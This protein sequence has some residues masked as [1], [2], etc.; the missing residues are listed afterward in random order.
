T[1]WVSTNGPDQPSYAL[2][3]A[4]VGGKIRV[5][6]SYT[7]GQGFEESVT[8][9]AIDN[10]EAVNDGRS[11]SVT[12][13]GTRSEKGTLNADTSGLTDPDGLGTFRYDWQRFDGTS[14]VS[15][16]GPD[17][18]SYAL[19]A[20]D[21]G[22]KIRVV[23]SYTDGQGFEESVT[24]GAI[25]NI[26]AVNDGRSGSVTIFGTTSE[27]GTLQADTSGLTDPDG[28]GTFRYDWQRFDGTSW[29]STNAPDKASYA[30]GA[31]DVGGKIR[32]VVSYTDGQGFEESVTSGS[33]DNIE[34][35]NDGRSGE[36]SIEGFLT[37]D[38]VLT[39][40]T[41][42]LIDPDGLGTLH[43]DWQRFDGTDWI[44][45]DGA[46]Q[47]TYTLGDADVGARI[48]VIVS[49][50]DGQG[51][52]ES[53]T[54][55]GSNT[56][57]AVND[58][59]LGGV[60][61]DGS[62][63][64]DEVLTANTGTLTDADGLGTL[65]Y[66]WQRLDGTDW[67]S[68][69][70]ANQSTYRLG[71]ADADTRIRVIVSYTDGQGFEESIT[72]AGTAIIGS[73]NDPY[74]GDVSIEGSLV[75][76][77]VLT[78]K[79][80]TLTDPDGLGTLSYV[81][82]RFDGD[83]WVSI[84]GAN[85][86][87]YRLGD[88]DVG[89]RIRVIVSYTD[90]QGY[91]ERITSDGSDTIGAF[92][93]GRSGEVSIEGSLTEDQVLTAKTD[94]LADPD[95][96]GT[97]RYDWQRFDG[98]DW[99][100]IDGANQSTYRLG[101]ADVGAK[102]R[103]TV[104]YTDG[105]GFAESSTSAGSGIIGGVNDAPVLTGTLSSRVTEGAS[106]VLTL[107]E[108]GY[109]DPDNGADDVTFTVSGLVNGTVMVNG[110]AATSFTG[111]ELAAGQV[112]FLHDGSETAVAGFNVSV[113]D[114]DED[115]SAPASGVFNFKVDAE[116]D[117]PELVAPLEN[118]R[119]AQGGAF[120]FTLPDGAFADDDAGD[121]LTYSAR[122][123]NGAALPGWLVFDPATNTF[124]G[125]PGGADVG[126]LSIRVTATD[127]GGASVSDEFD[128]TVA[129]SAGS[130]GDILLSS[131]H[132]KENAAAGTVVGTL[133]VP[134]A[135][136][137]DSFTYKLIQNPQDAFAIVN[138]K[139]V[140][141]KGADLDFEEKSL[142]R[143]TIRATDDDGTR[144]RETFRIDIDDVTEN[145]KGTRGNDRLIGDAGD[146]RLRGRQGDDI[147]KGMG[148]DD[149]IRS[150]RGD[151]RFWGNAGADIFLF[152]KRA[153]NDVVEDFDRN[154]GDQVRFRSNSGIDSFA[155]LMDNHLEVRRNGVLIT[156]DDGSTLL[157]RHV[158]AVE[159]SDFIF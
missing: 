61:I 47:S 105:Q 19:S 67:V 32:V 65:H 136:P 62:R 116:N 99:V 54:S 17:Q 80:D 2:S 96:L 149:T 109:T 49:Y 12:I 113:E 130:N 94:T 22:G 142:Y 89:A 29:I 77:Q 4:D 60:S 75:E 36:V 155:D 51:F 157:L 40:N 120:T 150:D 59:H 114:G 8:S 126:T 84:D 56:I 83:E 117:A 15:T 35:V 31:V 3:A 100:S 42:T 24:S 131:Q 144:Y 37:E 88:A 112:A 48:R 129:A 41:D 141:A 72:S 73:L 87:T 33:I 10:I 64:E 108:L 70:G 90:G 28:L 79:T 74:S 133:S 137:G 9:G 145:P 118:Q 55:D 53:I 6:V 98:T 76:D 30:L 57:G 156:D 92:N 13:F 143:V 148:G 91:R 128:I 26:E 11:G 135:D 107:S 58:P 1:S 151:D 125:T 95:G 82:Q 103:V 101:D 50:T 134:A 23:V 127:P 122:L 86:S 27:K 71:D 146:N 132:V 7:D 104:S 20:A 111:A 153:G 147:I 140:V 152:G 66:V 102:I 21:V 52:K 5:V 38:Q 115:S 119:A 110:T 44:S 16:N 121:V 14:W 138:G 154:E 106:H 97:F 46:N 124:S 123:A 45:I 78:A 25:D 34:A 158:R 139:L 18:P 68:I 85:Q 93:D 63:M 39:A 81:W 69:D 43:Y 159:E